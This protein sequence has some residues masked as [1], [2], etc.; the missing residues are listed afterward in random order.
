MDWSSLI[1]LLLVVVGILFGQVLEGGRLSSLIQPAA[2]VIVVVAT[3]GAV[4]LQSRMP[5]FIR[6]VKMLKWIFSAPED[7]TKRTI[8]DAMVW[9]SVARR[10]G[11]LSLERYMQA[12]KDPF[13][14][15]GLRLVIDGIDPARL[16]DILDVDISL[17]EMEQRQAVKV[18]ESAGGYSPTI[19][20]LGAVLGLIHVMENL[21]DPSKLGGGI[22]VAFVAT[23]YGVGLANL[24]YIPVGNKLK[25]IVLREVTRREMLADIFFSIALGDSTRLVE[26]RLANHRQASA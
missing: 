13:I 15:K 25:E 10:E 2:F 1:G 26:E 9:S 22:A 3:V 6:G 23:I 20:I 18:W 14:A 24:F 17:Y 7:N 4:M 11:F 12:S 5:V 16:K 19:G 8:Q 21:T